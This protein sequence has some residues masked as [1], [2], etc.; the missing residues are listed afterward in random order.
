LFLAIREEYEMQK[1]NGAVVEGMLSAK[2]LR[3]KAKLI[4][5]AVESDAQV[6]LYQCEDCGEPHF[7]IT[8]QA[9]GSDE[10]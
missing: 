3:K 10:S 1:L 8:Y 7:R 6:L 4:C 2:L 9:K 5:E